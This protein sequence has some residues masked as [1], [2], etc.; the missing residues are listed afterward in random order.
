MFVSDKERIRLEEQGLSEQD[1]K[2]RFLKVKVQVLEAIEYDSFFMR[3]M[4]S[5]KT[6]QYSKQLY[7]GMVKRSSPSIIDVFINV[8]DIE[9]STTQS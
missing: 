8:F 7:E 3:V 2:E 5:G 4:L 1:F 6:W 9:C